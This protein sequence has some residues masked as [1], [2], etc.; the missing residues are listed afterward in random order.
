MTLYIDEINSDK[1]QR[2]TFLEFL[3][4]FSRVADLASFTPSLPKNVEQYKMNVMDRQS[5]MLIGKIENVV[6]ILI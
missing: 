6:D 3:E 1:H 4:A 2:M 5:Q